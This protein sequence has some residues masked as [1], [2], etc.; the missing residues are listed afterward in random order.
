MFYSHIGQWLQDPCT[1]DS[2]AESGC[3]VNIY[4]WWPSFLLHQISLCLQLCSCSSFT[5]LLW[6]SYTAEISSFSYSFAPSCKWEDCLYKRLGKGRGQSKF[7]DGIRP[8]IKASSKTAAE[9]Q[10]NGTAGKAL[11]LH[12]GDSSSVTGTLYGPPSQWWPQST[13]PGI[14][15]ELHWV[16]PKN[17]IMKTILF[18]SESLPM[19][20][21]ASFL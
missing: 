1:Q 8:S 16:W 2:V 3:P 9:S 11:A 13:E 19:S 15:P 4:E 21:E 6:P 20:H 5:L 14:N 12:I 10:S 17:K 7:R 18:T